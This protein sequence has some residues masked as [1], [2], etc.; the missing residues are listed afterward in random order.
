MKKILLLL[1]GALISASSMAQAGYKITGTVADLPDGKLYLVVFD[2]KMP[3]TIDS[4]Q[5]A[6]GKFQFTGKIGLPMAA[7]IR[8]ADRAIIPDPF[9]LENSPITVAGSMADPKKIEIKGSTANDEYAAL[10]NAMAG[11]GSLSDYIQAKPGSVVAA[12]VLYRTAYMYDYKELDELVDT[13]TP[14]VQPSVY[15]QIC[16]QTAEKLERVSV[17]KPYVDFTLP[18]TTGTAVALSSIVA[19]HKYVLVDFWASW[20]GP[21]RRENPHVVA[22]Y[23]AFKDK[24]FTVVGVSLDRPGEKAS[25]MAA[26]A[27]DNLTW[28]HLSDLKFWNCEAADLY[29]VRSI[30]SNVLI[31]PDGTI[32]AK[33]L[34]GDALTAKLAELMP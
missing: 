34:R 24:G 3:R 32:V 20:C 15:W 16:Q 29:A 26:I 14:A 7:G 25:W 10:S 11:G 30:P 22:A 13:F 33:N 27:K 18:D 8:T 6:G 2:G 28:P 21:C 9:F 5:S 12:Y 1:A 31:G 23:Q 4:T 19:K 17:G